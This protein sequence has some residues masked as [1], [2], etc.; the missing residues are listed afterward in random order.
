MDTCTK[1]GGLRFFFRITLITLITKK[2]EK[3]TAPVGF[4]FLL[5]K[6]F[7]DCNNNKIAKRKRDRK[8]R[9]YEINKDVF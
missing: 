3:S 1:F 8:S 2:E 6:A 9:K 5:S 7:L 4:V